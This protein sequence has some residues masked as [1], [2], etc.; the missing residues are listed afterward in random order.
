MANR[1]YRLGQ[2]TRSCVYI[3]RE[4]TPMAGMRLRRNDQFNRISNCLTSSKSEKPL[5]GS[6]PT[7]DRSISIDPDDCRHYLSS[8]DNFRASPVIRDW[9]PTSRP[10]Q[11][12]GILD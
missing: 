8:V 1:H 3:P 10:A 6:I 11:L 2:R 4:A 12:P 5:G 7:V 9:H